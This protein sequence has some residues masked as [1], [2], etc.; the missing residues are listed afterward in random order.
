[1]L[2]LNRSYCQALNEIFLEER[3][4][5]HDRSDNDQYRCHCGRV[6]R[7]ITTHSC[8]R[9]RRYIGVIQ[10]EFNTLLNTYEQE[11]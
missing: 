10:Q 5:H 9:C 1:M 2:T 11:L 3:I 6:L 8:S 4:Y 7:N